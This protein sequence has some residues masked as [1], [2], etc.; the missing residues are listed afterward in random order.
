M[1]AGQLFLKGIYKL[2]SHFY[3]KNPF[4]ADWIY[5]KYQRPASLFRLGIN[6]SY[7]L[8]RINRSPYLLTS[9]V[10]ITTQCNLHCPMCRGVYSVLQND[11]PISK[12]FY[13][14]ILRRLPRSIESVMMTQSGEPFLHPKIFELIDLTRHYGFRPI[15]FTNGTLLNEKIDRQILQSKLDTIN[16]SSEID[17]DNSLKQRGISLHRI[18]NNI[19][20]LL[21]LRRES[22]SP[23]KVKLSVVVHTQNKQNLSTFLKKWNPHVDAIKVNPMYLN[24]LK[25]RPPKL[26]NEIWRGH[27]SIRI[28][29]VISPCCL[30]LLGS[31]DIGNIK[32]TDA[33]HAW[34]GKKFH[35]LRFNFLNNNF[36][37]ICYYCTWDESAGLK[38]IHS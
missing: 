7:Y 29:G 33:L 18:E 1:N 15:I 2:I 25:T 38:R 5:E 17:E 13:E 35:V 11:G 27:I 19:I 36:P 30:D 10:D 8:L 21:K 24:I 28:N 26:C 32:N 37:K 20:T 14:T 6:L 16:I 34:N 3:F 22:H 4:M 12:E 23:L 9:T 31:L